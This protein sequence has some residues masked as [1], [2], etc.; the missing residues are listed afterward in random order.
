MG[1][2]SCGFPLKNRESRIEN[3]LGLSKQSFSI[4]DHTVIS[5][6]IKM[7]RSDNKEF[8]LRKLIVGGEESRVF[9]IRMDGFCKVMP[10]P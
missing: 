3:Q 8:I 6:F 4:I 1:Q 7:P 5:L 9:D 2:K 10:F